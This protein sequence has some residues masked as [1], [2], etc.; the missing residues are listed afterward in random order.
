MSENFR[1]AG[2]SLSEA[3]AAMEDPE[4]GSLRVLKALGEAREFFYHKL[5]EGTRELK[6]EDDFEAFAAE[7]A[8]GDFQE[9]LKSRGE[10][11]AP[12]LKVVKKGG[13][14]V[15]DAPAENITREEALA[16]LNNPEGGSLRVLK[17]VGKQRDLYFK[18]LLSGRKRLV[19]RNPFEEVC[20]EDAIR[21][22]TEDLANEGQDVPSDL[23]LFRSGS[24]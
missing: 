17:A 7:L 5:Q 23:T 4:K 16:A 22:Y 24:F 15:S 21:G 18:E 20:A 9:D 8:L 3:K 12:G 2:I 11:L 10:G 19:V 14:K 1:G 6:P 13:A